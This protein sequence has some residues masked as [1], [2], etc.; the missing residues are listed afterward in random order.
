MPPAL[1]PSRAVYAFVRP[2]GLVAGTEEAEL[3]RGGDGWRIH[4]RIETAWPEDIVATLEWDLD[5][6]LVTRLLRIESRER[7]T[8]ESE[9][10]LTITGNGLLAHRRAED[11]PTQVELGWGPNAELDYVSAAFPTVLLARSALQPGQ[12]REVDAVQIGT[13][14]L[15]PGIVSRRLRA[16][17][18]GEDDTAA[19]VA[20]DLGVAGGAPLRT[21][22]RVDCLTVQTGHVAIATASAEGVLLGYAGLLRLTSLE[23]K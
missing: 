9:L 11:G 15:L 6:D 16:V 13:A 1:L 2:D 22:R 12:T 21:A 7:F 20:L 19:P 4:S 10:E 8:G 3:T 23:S 5:R 18:P 17:A 14:D